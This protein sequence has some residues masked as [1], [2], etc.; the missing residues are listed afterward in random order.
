MDKYCQKA[1]VNK[2]NY[3]LLA[4]ACFF[5][6]GKYEEIATPR[7]KK[8]VGLCDGLFDSAD[9]LKMESKIFIQMDFLISQPTVNWFLGTYLHL[10]KKNIGEE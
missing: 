2:Q 9:L 5:I 10:I 1:C 3:Q 8:I 7:M 6:A 4:A